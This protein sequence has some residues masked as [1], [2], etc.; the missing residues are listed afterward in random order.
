MDVQMKQLVAYFFLVFFCFSACFAD[1][2][3]ISAEQAFQFSATAKDY[4]TVLLTWKIARGYYLYQKDFKFT[5]IKPT[6][7]VLGDPLYPNDTETLNTI[8]GKLKVYS[9]RL[10]IPIPIIHIDQKTLLLQ[11]H[12]QGCSKAGYCYPPM[13]KTIEINLA[14]NYL[15]SV[16]PINIDIAPA[17][18]ATSQ[19]QFEKLLNGH[20]ILVLILGFL[21]F[22]I[23]L[24][25]TPCVLPMIP[26]LSS[27]I[28]GRENKHAFLLS[29]FYVFGMSITYAI[30]GIFFGYIGGNIQIIFQ[31]PWIIILF[32][33]LFIVMSLSMFGLFQ[34]QLPEKLRSKIASA[35]YHQKGGTYFGAIMMGIL[36]TLI[37]SPCVTPPLVAAF[38][39]IS[40]TGN[41]VIGGAVLF[42]MGVGMGTPLLLIGALGPRV[43][44]KS[45]EWMNAVKI[46]MGFLLLAVAID[47]V[48][49]ITP[50]FI[51]LILW[52]ALCLGAS[53]YLGTFSTAK[54]RWKIIKKFVGIILFILSVALMAKTVHPESEKKSG[55]IFQ[56][57]NTVSQ[58]N[59]ALMTASKNNQ[60]VMLD[61]YANW[62]VSCK[63]LD[64]LTF[65]NPAVEKQLNHF[66][67]LRADIT[68]DSESN[69]VLMKQY[70]VVAP[71][72]ILFFRNGREI[73]LSRVIGFLSAKPFLKKISQY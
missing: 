45:G 60:T 9:H 54:T 26:I 22:G 15:Q 46:F 25:L 2:T 29:L 10:T 66:V 73:P 23:L 14:G 5:A 48:Q 61:F 1:Q 13:T 20:S 51:T 65:H 43:L 68:N 34:L 17:T 33:L 4:Q 55:L 16:S 32:S 37:L 38:S 27:M 44:P 53:I 72:T 42:A 69:Q 40:Q 19:N 7:T 52:A 28:V 39:F 71:P 67:L 8:E 6:N 35:S 3:P 59:T 70:N 31:Q 49:R 47:M 36:S 50:E 57:V 62:C 56:P 58:I 21:G 30:A 12:Y 41:A 64:A 11:V 63:E 24:S 18:Q